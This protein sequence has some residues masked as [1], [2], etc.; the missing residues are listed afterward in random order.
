MSVAE[1]PIP[2]AT[3]AYSH[4]DEI[5]AR[6]AHWVTSA[7]TGATNGVMR[8]ETHSKS[9][10]EKRGAGTSQKRLDS[11]TC[12]GWRGRRWL[13]CLVR[14]EGV[15]EILIFRHVCPSSESFQGPPEERDRHRCRPRKL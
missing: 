10:A 15:V 4:E 12:K 11:G 13:Q 8:S 5:P 7:S 1:V 14:L 2:S 6:D 3:A 9:Y